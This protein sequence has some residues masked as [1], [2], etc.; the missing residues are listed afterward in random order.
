MKIFKYPVDP[1]GDFIVDMPAGA[2]VLSVQ[3]QNGSP[4]M[5]AMVNEDAKLV[6][7]H[8]GVFGTG[9]HIPDDFKGRFIGTFQ[10][11]GGSLAF[12]L[13]ELG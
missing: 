2:K 1:S 11:Q 3:V 13:F 5:W 9:W 4:Q 7:R 8:F 6:Q 12:H 10:L